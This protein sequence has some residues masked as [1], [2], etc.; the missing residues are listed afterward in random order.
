MNAA[1]AQ[2]LPAAPTQ[3]SEKDLL[4]ASRS[5]TE[6]DRTKSWLVTFSSLAILAGLSAG[7]MFAPWWPLRLL[8]AL[9]QPDHRAHLLSVPRLSARRDLAAVEGR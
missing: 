9:V 1:I 4:I 3:R 5:F 6:E 2:P 7:S 8:F